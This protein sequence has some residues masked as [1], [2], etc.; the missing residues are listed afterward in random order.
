MHHH[1]AAVRAGT[2]SNTGGAFEVVLEDLGPIRPPSTVQAATPLPVELASR[3]GA[4][5]QVELRGGRR[6]A[7]T[8]ADLAA[9]VDTTL[10]I[11]GP[12]GEALG[13]NDDSGGTLASRL[14]LT[15]PADG[16]YRIIVR[17]IGAAGRFTLL[18]RE[19]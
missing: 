8:T 12:A 16:V 11:L 18:V 9:K 14:A 1:V 19:E 7:V 6:Y 4:A 17:N 2:L 10:A 5:F 15:P 13:E 3:R